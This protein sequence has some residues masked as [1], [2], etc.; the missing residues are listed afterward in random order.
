MCGIAGLSVAPGVEID[1]TATARL[2][3]AGLAERGQD[4]TGYAFHR[5]DGRV[6]VHKDS[7]PLSSFIEQLDDVPEEREVGDHDAAHEIAER[8]DHRV[9]PGELE[10]VQ[11]AV[12]IVA[13]EAGR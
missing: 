13:S 8:P 7:V 12:A 2:L 1:A 10:R 4:A 11:Q 6:E 9:L 5:E 3:L